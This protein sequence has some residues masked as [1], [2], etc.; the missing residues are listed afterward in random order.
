MWLFLLV[1]CSTPSSGCEEVRIDGRYEARRCIEAGDHVALTLRVRD[2]D[3]LTVTPGRLPVELTVE[4]WRLESV[5]ID[6]VE[7]QSTS[8]PCDWG[9]LGECWRVQRRVEKPT[10]VRWID[11]WRR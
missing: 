8:F 7:V 1:A 5:H 3:S 4:A 6:E 11:A 10:T 9:A 2:I